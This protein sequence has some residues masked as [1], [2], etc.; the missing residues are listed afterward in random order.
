MPSVI[1]VAWDIAPLLVGLTSAQRNEAKQFC[2]SAVG[3]V[4]RE[5]GHQIIN[6]RGSARASG[7][8]TLGAVWGREASRTAAKE[9]EKTMET[10]E[11]VME[12]YR[13]TLAVLAK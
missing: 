8:F 9:F 10:A 2:G 4:M 12:Q 13:D 1:A 11:E 6:P 3:E 5:N 7:V